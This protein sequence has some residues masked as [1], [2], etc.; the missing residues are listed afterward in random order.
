MAKCGSNWIMFVIIILALGV[1]IILI[2]NIDIYPTNIQ[3]PSSLNQQTSILSHH[4]SQHKYI[5]NYI[6]SIP[7][8]ISSYNKSIAWKLYQNNSGNLIYFHPRKAA[9]TTMGIWLEKV[10]NRNRK[11]ENQFKSIEAFSN[12]HYKKKRNPIDIEMRDKSNLSLFAISF[13]DPIERIVSHYEFEFRWGCNKCC[14]TN[15]DMLQQPNGDIDNQYPNMNET[16]FLKVTFVKDWYK[17][18]GGCTG[19]DRPNL[20]KHKLCNIE[21]DD[22]LTRIERFELNNNSL[23][24]INGNYSMKKQQLVGG[25]YI[26]NYYLW[27]FCCNHKSCNIL[28]DFILTNKIEIC[29]NETIK[30]IKS[31]DIIVI[32]EWLNDIRSSIYV[33]KMLYEGN[34][35]YRFILVS[36]KPY[37]HK[38]KYRGS[39]YMLNK[40]V[41]N[42]LIEWNKWDIKLYQ[43]VKTLVYQRMHN[44]WDSKGI[45]LALNRHRI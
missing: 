6:D 30:K 13:R 16:N 2:I 31:M 17:F 23:Y 5:K 28:K 10:I 3:Q 36:P 7:P 22:L 40:K 33:N 9:G 44:I 27:M 34:N 1:T 24:G 25:V 38:E 21:L 35:G 8:L 18:D 20:Y 39:N 15:S 41:Y 26:S 32:T 29:F 43:F 4:L 45:Q 14:H 11:T 19:H 12:W 37:P 42:K